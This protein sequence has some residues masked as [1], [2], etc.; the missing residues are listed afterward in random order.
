MNPMIELL[1]SIFYP[2]LYFLV[3]YVVMVVVRVLTVFFVSA[4]RLRS[5]HAIENYWIYVLLTVFCAMT[6]VIFGH[7]NSVEFARWSICP[8]VAGLIGI[9]QGY[10]K[11]VALT[12]EELK[13]IEDEAEQMKKH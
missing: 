2:L 10:D 9:H 3:L 12:D 1:L 5:F 13:E 7:G 8:L 6:G 4:G 11:G